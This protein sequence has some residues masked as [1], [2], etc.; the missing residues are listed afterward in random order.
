MPFLSHDRPRRYISWPAVSGTPPP[1]AHAISQAENPAHK[2]EART[3]W[4]QDRVQGLI[5]LSVRRKAREK[6]VPGVAYGLASRVG[7]GEKNKLSNDG[8]WNWAHIV[9]LL[10]TGFYLP[11]VPDISGF[12]SDE[13]CVSPPLSVDI[14]HTAQC[15]CARSSPFRVINSIRKKSKVNNGSWPTRQS[16]LFLVLFSSSSYA[17]YDTIDDGYFWAGFCL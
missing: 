6:L 16:S 17:A 13:K 9:S 11:K 14:Q 4:I 1:A 8:G 15:P 3:G 5:L 7:R 10:C 12:Y 2:I